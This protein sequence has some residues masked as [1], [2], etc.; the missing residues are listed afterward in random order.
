MLL[1][2]GSLLEFPLL[3]SDI[4]FRGTWVICYTT[5]PLQTQWLETAVLFCSQSLRSGIWERPG[6]MLS[7]G[8]PHGD[9]VDVICSYRHLRALLSGHSRWHRHAAGR[10]EAQAGL[11]PEHPELASLHGWG[12]LTAW[13]LSSQ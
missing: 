7:L 2:L 9:A 8:V 10:L 4:C 13:H 3:A 5:K 11:R 1:L 6:W 12:V